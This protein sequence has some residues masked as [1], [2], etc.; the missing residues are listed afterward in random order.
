LLNKEPA[1]GL[2]AKTT[3]RIIEGEVLTDAAGSFS[4]AFITRGLTY[5]VDASD[6]SGGSIEVLDASAVSVKDTLVVLVAKRR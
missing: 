4:A 3:E 2:I 1:L 5:R 6:A